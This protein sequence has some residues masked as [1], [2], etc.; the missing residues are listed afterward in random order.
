MSYDTVTQVNVAFFFISFS[1]IN[2]QEKKVVPLY[3]NSSYLHLYDVCQYPSTKCLMGYT[4]K[5]DGKFYHTL[6]IYF[7]DQ[8][9]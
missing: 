8:S 5:H 1:S 2:E 7:S 4:N 6:S 3:Y 9:S